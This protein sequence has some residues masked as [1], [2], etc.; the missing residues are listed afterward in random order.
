MSEEME[1]LKKKIQKIED[2]VLVTRILIC[3]LSVIILLVAISD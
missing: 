3:F 1:K 2:D